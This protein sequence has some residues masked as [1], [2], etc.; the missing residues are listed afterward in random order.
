MD[1]HILLSTIEKKVEINLLMTSFLSFPWGMTLVSERRQVGEKLPFFP[2]FS[3]GICFQLYSLENQFP[4]TVH[5]VSFSF[6]PSLIYQ[7]HS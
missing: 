7:F 1:L 3:G 5:S 2:Q 4:M 6:R